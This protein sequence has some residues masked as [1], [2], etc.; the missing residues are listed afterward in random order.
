M[1]NLFTR[2]GETLGRWFSA[3]GAMEAPAAD[4]CI[5]AVELAAMEDLQAQ[6]LDAASLDLALE[7]AAES[8]PLELPP[9][10]IPAT[11]WSDTAPTDPVAMARQAEVSMGRI[12]SPFSLID[13]PT[14]PAV[15][16][17]FVASPESYSSTEQVKPQPQPR[18]RPSV[19]FSQLYKLISQEVNKRTDGVIDMYEKVLAAGR[20]ELDG[21]RRSQRL[22]WSVGGVMTA[23]AAFTGIYAAGE[24]GG[25]HAEISS[26][27]HQAVAGAQ[28]IT[29]R[30]QLRIDLMKVKDSTVKVEI[31]ALKSRLDQALA[32]SSERDRLRLEVET[33]RKAK[34]DVENELKMIQKLASTP[35]TQPVSDARSA[36]PRSTQERA[37]GSERTDVWSVLLNGRE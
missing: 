3:R 24:V 20:Q 33:L 23:V 5:E 1:A 37:V 32:V 28:A 31:D 13:P 18:P 16:I 11:P 25:N 9:L 29:D 22:A 34:L 2:I 35:A 17:G 8:E 21:V 27:R 4:P 15:P 6:P 36:A 14:E 10:D 12:D 30:D 19:S 7:E 26:L